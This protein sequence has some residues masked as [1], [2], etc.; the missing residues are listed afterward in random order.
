MKV[1]E[2]ISQPGVQLVEGIPQNVRFKYLTYRIESD[3][4]ATE[5][6]DIFAD[7]CDIL[8]SNK[9]YIFVRQTI[10]VKIAL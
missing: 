3:E 2:K 1:Y 8:F 9:E 4:D 6:T 10:A 5:L 7:G